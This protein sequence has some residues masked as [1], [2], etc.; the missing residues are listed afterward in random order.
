MEEIKEYLIRC[1]STPP[2][3]PQRVDHAGRGEPV[4]LY[5]YLDTAERSDTE[6]AF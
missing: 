1:S 4:G 6:S 3:E 2:P 5:I